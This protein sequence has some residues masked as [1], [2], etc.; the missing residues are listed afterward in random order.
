MGADDDSAAWAIVHDHPYLEM[1]WWVGEH[2]L[3]VLFGWLMFRR[4]MRTTV[5]VSIQR[6]AQVL[7]CAGC[8]SAAFVSS[9]VRQRGLRVHCVECGG[10]G[11][12][13][14]AELRHSMA[15]HMFRRG[16]LESL[17]V[18][19]SPIPAR[20]FLKRLTGVRFS[21]AVF[22]VSLLVLSIVWLSRG[23]L[24]I[25]ASLR[26]RQVR[27]PGSGLPVC[28]GRRGM[29]DCL[30]WFAVVLDARRSGSGAGRKDR[31]TSGS[32]RDRQS[33]THCAVV[34]GDRWR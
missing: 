13:H 5:A 27:G 2:I 26:H 18:T 1:L 29:R 21:F 17:L 25:R 15:W 6:P 3:I 28:H 33:P 34:G 30:V 12:L 32:S 20:P 11:L 23:F 24:E 19:G 22:F 8:R 16:S 10:R 4:G 7:F 9:G 14:D 31:E